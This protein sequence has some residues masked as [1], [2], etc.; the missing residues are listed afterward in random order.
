MSDKR[1]FLKFH[2]PHTPYAKG[3]VATF[4]EKDAKK[5]KD[6]ADKVKEIKKDGK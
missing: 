2:A 4:N 5:H 1:V 6:F 3:D